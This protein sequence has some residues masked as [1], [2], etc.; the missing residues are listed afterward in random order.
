MEMKKRELSYYSLYLQRVRQE[1][2][3]A[4]A[5]VD[6]DFLDERSAAAEEAFEESRRDGLTVGQA[7]ERAM[8]VLLDGWA[9]QSPGRPRLE[10]IN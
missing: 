1:Q 5:T 7:Q 6:D 9:V 4:I 10:T 2:G 8:S 3:D